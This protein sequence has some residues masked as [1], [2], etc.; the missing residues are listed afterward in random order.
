MT[1]VTFES[2]Y[3][4]QHFALPLSILFTYY[5]REIWKRSFISTVRSIVHT[6]PLRKWSFSKNHLMKRKEFE[7]A[8][9][10]RL[11]CRRKTLWKRSFSKRWRNRV[12]SLPEFSSNL[13]SKIADDCCFLKFLWICR[14]RT[15][16]SNFPDVV[17]NGP[18]IRVNYEKSSFLVS[19]VPEP[20]RF[21][22]KMT[23]SQA[24]S[25]AQAQDWLCACVL[26]K[27]YL[28]LAKSIAVSILRCKIPRCKCVKNTSN[29]FQHR[30]QEY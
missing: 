19:L 30:Q 6:N 20:A 13:K 22:S 21:P 17:W 15:P 3:V 16:F 27:R 5:A 14:V 23:E 9:D 28:L 2:H 7:N 4:T 12:I 11:I 8:A 18:T 25:P 24:Q 29:L 26:V 1:C 10:L